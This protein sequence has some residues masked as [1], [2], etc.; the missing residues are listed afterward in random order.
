M[1]F[2]ISKK[3]INLFLIL[4]IVCLISFAI[5]YYAHSIR[6]NK[7]VALNGEEAGMAYRSVYLLPEHKQAESY[8]TTSSAVVYYWIGSYLLPITV[9]SQRIF[10]ILGMSFLPLIMILT[11]REIIIY[12]KD[13]FFITR[14]PFL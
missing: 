8:A 6:V 12:L 10:K 2:K 1:G 3:S 5:L 4:I 13:A 9:N 11:M 14:I 7:D